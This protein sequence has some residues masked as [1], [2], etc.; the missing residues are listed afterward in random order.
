MDASGVAGVGPPCPNSLMSNIGLALPW[1]AE[2]LMQATR[3][4]PGKMERDA[5]G[6]ADDRATIIP[7]VP[8]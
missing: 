2:L 7:Y 8:P 6:H 4:H 1:D 5:A 3:E